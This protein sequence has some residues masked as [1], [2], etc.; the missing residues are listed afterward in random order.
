MFKSV[1]IA[2]VAMIVVTGL[3][4]A[5]PIHAQGRGY[6]TPEA[7]E[8]LVRFAIIAD[9]TGGERP[10]VFKVGA[11]AVRAM[12]PDFIMSIGDLIEGGTED[13]DQM[14]KEWRT[15]NENL[16]KG[17]LDFYPVVGNHDISN[18][19]M[20]HWYEKVVAPRYYHFI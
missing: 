11:E 5:E 19:A 10:G 13:V 8:S 2:F 3:S 14:N 6:N 20:R 16:N 1:V 9:L 4:N 18:T 12:K 7:D 17:D 15:F